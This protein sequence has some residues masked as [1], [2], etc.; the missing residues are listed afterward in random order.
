M[1][2]IVI[3]KSRFIKLEFRITIITIII[4]IRS[5]MYLVGEKPKSGLIAE[6]I[7][8][9]KIKLLNNSYMVWINYCKVWFRNHREL[10]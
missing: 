4:G 10:P 5:R 6:I 2:N 1:W 9:G 8:W 7:R 3:R